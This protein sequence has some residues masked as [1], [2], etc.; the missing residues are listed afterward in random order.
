MDLGLGFDDEDFES[1]KQ[2]GQ[3]NKKS[4]NAKFCSEYW[5]YS[6]IPEPENAGVIYKFRGD[7]LYHQKSYTEALD[8]YKEGLESLPSNNKTLRQDILECMARCYL[9]TEKYAEALDIAQRLIVD[10]KSFDQI[11]QTRLLLSQIQ[12]KMN[13][14]EGLE[15]SLKLLLTM[16]PFTYSL[17]VKLGQCYQIQMENSKNNIN[18]VKLK[19][20]SCLVRVRLLLR[21]IIRNS[22]SFYKE[23]L[24]R[25][26]KKTE[27]LQSELEVPDHIVHMA[28]KHLKEDLGQNEDE[29][30]ESNRQNDSP[31]E[32]GQGDVKNFDQRWFSW[33][34]HDDLT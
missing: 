15:E 12:D 8:L 30:V 11:M 31:V 34:Q 4:Y 10:A 22:G 9:H 20:L 17:W 27:D 5:Y 16:H 6:E 33:I 26:L 14:I 21:N 25:L 24:L 18:S 29:N 3:D 32:A 2:S 7:N 28:A 13:D 1:K 19:R 23:K